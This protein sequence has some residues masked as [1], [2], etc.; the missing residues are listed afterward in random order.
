[1]FPAAL[2]VLLSLIAVPAFAQAPYVGA[3]VGMDVARYDHVEFPGSGDFDASGEAVAFSLRV[4]TP[5]G[6]NWGV[7]LGFTY[8]SEIEREN[9]QGFPIPLLAAASLAGI[10]AGVA[11][12]PGGN[13]TFP[14]F[15]ASTEVE[16]R[17]VTLDT[18]AWF[19]QSVG[20]RVD[21]VYLGGVAFNR[22]TEEITF[23]FN[24][25]QAGLIVPTSTRSVSYGV[26]PVVGMEARIGLTDHVRLVPAFRLQSVGGNSTQ[27]GWLIRPSAGL[28]WQF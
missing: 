4:G 12:P 18:V 8:P 5:I 11:L 28:A 19:A 6:Q 9:S 25:R 21:L 23:Q 14:V 7:E 2:F 13:L 22:V 1:M 15:E 3:A 24:R 20:S 26:G 27:G 17:N 10:G 16:R